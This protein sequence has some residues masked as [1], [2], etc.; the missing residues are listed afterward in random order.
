[1]KKILL[2]A[3][4]SITLCACEKDEAYEEK[5][6]PDISKSAVS[7]NQ[8][9]AVITKL[10]QVKMRR[11]LMIPFSAYVMQ[12]N[13]RDYLYMI[14]L[15]FNQD[16]KVGDAIDFSVFSFCP[17]EIAKINGCDLGDGS[18]ASQNGNSNGIGY[19][20]A[21]D[22][23]EAQIKDIFSMKIRYSISFWPIDTWFIETTNGNLVFIKK[24]KVNVSLAPGDRIVYSKYT[25]YDELLTLKKL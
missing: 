18:S 13:N 11:E 2:F 1:M 12:I 9:Q 16:L 15:R 3:L 4:L 17:N 5:I 10:H 23:I 25:L 14:R 19:L 21:T 20:V 7:A 24:S 6:V 8:Q 22:P